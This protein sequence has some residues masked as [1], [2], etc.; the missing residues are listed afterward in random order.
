[1][2]VTDFNKCQVKILEAL[3]SDGGCSSVLDMTIYKGKI[4][5]VTVTKNG[6]DLR[7]QGMCTSPLLNNPTSHF[8]IT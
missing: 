5:L 7:K 2:L 6:Q 8:T 3:D 4:R 1:M